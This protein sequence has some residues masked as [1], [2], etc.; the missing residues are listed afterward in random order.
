VIYL[1]Q[2]R[3]KTQRGPVPRSPKEQ[4]PPK[5]SKIFTKSNFTKIFLPSLFL[6]AVILTPVL[7][8]AF[9]TRHQR[10]DDI[11]DSPFDIDL[12]DL[13]NDI[14]PGLDIDI[15]DLI[16]GT[17]DFMDGFTNGVADPERIMFR[18]TPTDEYFYWRLEV[19][20]EYLM[21]IWGKNTTT[22]EIF[23]YSSHPAADDD[24]IFTVQADLAYGGGIIANNFPAPYHYLYN[25]VLANNTYFEPASEWIEPYTILEE[26]MYEVK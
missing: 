10:I 5:K 26:D 18:I 24:G 15:D 9:N 16:N 1:S 20:D 4:V 2:D 6:I 19:F 13:F 8:E 7:F 21:D 23:G 22:T 14:D 17:E 12:Y 25:E 11:I 3:G